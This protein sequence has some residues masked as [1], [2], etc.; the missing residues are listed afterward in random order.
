ML[1]IV[2][3][4]GNKSFIFSEILKRLKIFTESIV[5]NFSNDYMYIQG[6]DSSHVVIFEL[7]I[8]SKWFDTYVITKEQNYE[9]GIN[10][11]IISKI[12]SV[13]DESQ[14]IRL[15]QEDDNID[16]L[17]I[18]FI[19]TSSNEEIKKN[20]P[21]ND[22]KKISVKKK[23]TKKSKNDEE[24]NKI[25]QKLEEKIEKNSCYEKFFEIP[26]I[27]I[28]YD[29]LEIP[30]TDY[31]ATLQIES[32]NMKNLIDNFALFETSTIEFV[33]NQEDI[34]LQSNGIETNMEVNILHEQMELYS[35]TE[36]TKFINSFALKFIH[37]ICQFN[38]ISKL[39]QIQQ[40]KNMPIE[41]TYMI[42]DENT[43][44]FYIAPT[45]NEYEE[46]DNI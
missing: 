21:E 32:K 39:V 24:K 46:D 7:K 3:E 42:D 13:R 14:H 23:S 4:K 1:H 28:D 40:S 33:F 6:M 41:F 31:D 17:Q 26:L 2:V 38:K 29:M 8:Y 9:Y 15:H 44:R 36:N 30:P 10:T 16:K 25:V 5:I 45:I 18:S 22:E 34:C 20:T 19:N 35:I 27:D 11:N 37:N 12:L 43:F